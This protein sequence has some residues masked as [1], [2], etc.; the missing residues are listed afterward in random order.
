RGWI[1]GR[2]GEIYQ[3]RDGQCHLFADRPALQIE[4]L[5]AIW[6]DPDGGVW[7]AGGNV[8]SSTLDQGVILHGNRSITPWKGEKCEIPLEPGCPDDAVDPAP[9]GSIARRWNEQMLNAIRRDTP[10]PTVHA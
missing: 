1:S 10:R 2:D 7:A 8:I 6:E 3:E 5:H 4:S 9:E